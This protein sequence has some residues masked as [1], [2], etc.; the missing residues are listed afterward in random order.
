MPS[1]AGVARSGAWLQAVR[2]ALEGPLRWHRIAAPWWH[3][4]RRACIGHPGGHWPQLRS[5]AAPGMTGASS[6][7]STTASE[8]AR[9]AAKRII[10]LAIARRR[11]VLKGLYG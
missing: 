5:G 11:T 10:V 2:M 9:R 4:R 8:H 6:S 7:A 3:P 1:E